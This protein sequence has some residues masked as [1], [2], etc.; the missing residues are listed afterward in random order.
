MFDWMRHTLD[1]CIRH[2]IR[3]CLN[4][5]HWMILTAMS[6]VYVGNST[7]L[8]PYLR[9]GWLLEGFSVGWSCPRPFHVPSCMQAKVQLKGTTGKLGMSACLLLWPSINPL[10][11][12]G[13]SY[14]RN[15]RL[16]VRLARSGQNI[17]S[18]DELTVMTAHI[19]NLRNQNS[20]H[21]LTV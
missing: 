5:T 11:N 7:I 18:Y 19:N 10:S 16:L 9:Q 21:R 17:Y 12:V 2:S 14:G 13:V 6:C 20:V 1:W 3:L 4:K 8:P 15:C